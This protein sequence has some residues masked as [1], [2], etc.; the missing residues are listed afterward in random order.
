MKGNYISSVP[1][2]VLLENPNA[3]EA[4][5]HIGS[6]QPR[7]SLYH[8]FVTYLLFLIIETFLCLKP[9]R[10]YATKSAPQHFFSPLSTA[11]ASLQV[12]F[13]NY[14]YFMLLFHHASHKQPNHRTI[15]VGK[16]LW[17][18]SRP[19]DQLPCSKQGQLDL[20]VQV[21]VQSG[22]EH[23]PGISESYS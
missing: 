6:N 20:T 17:K 15:E 5:V 7:C 16:D 9:S 10:L 21:H 8:W 12:W 2:A 3:D 13:Y 11:V 4:L 14:L 19:T 23:L 18:L 1:C 22:F